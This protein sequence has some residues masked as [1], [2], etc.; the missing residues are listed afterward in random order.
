MTW[1]DCDDILLPGTIERCIEKLD[2]N[3]DAIGVYTDNIHVD[4]RLNKIKNGV[5]TGT[6]KWSLRK[7]PWLGGYCENIAVFRRA[8]IEKYLPELAVY[9][10]DA[11]DHW[12]RGVLGCEG[13]FIHLER[14]GVLYRRHANNASLNEKRTD[15]LK[16]YSDIYE[17]IARTHAE[18]AIDVHVL[19]CHEPKLWIDMC[20]K[21]LETEPVNVRF[22]QG[23]A[24]QV[25]E[26]RARA[27][28]QGSAK[29]V[30]FVS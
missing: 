23:I 14:P 2:A 25:G 17:R 28:A 11:C 9:N 29:Y 1:L 20:L 3:P 27:F 18:H 26:A 10:N 4:E 21:S 12:F 15:T 13:K 6:G 8:V 22:C 30:A 7:M 5:S 16:A 24:G 19:Y